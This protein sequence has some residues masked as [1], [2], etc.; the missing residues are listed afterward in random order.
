MMAEH[1]ML[2]EDDAEIHL[3]QIQALIETQKDFPNLLHRIPTEEQYGA[4]GTPDIPLG[5]LAE[6]P[7]LPFGLRMLDRPRHVLV[8]GA[9]GSGKTTAIR[10]I[11]RGIDQLNQQRSMSTTCSDGKETDRSDVPQ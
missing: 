1:G 3:C 7:T 9:T 10:L 8:A 6:E 11:I 5:F 4:A 2:S